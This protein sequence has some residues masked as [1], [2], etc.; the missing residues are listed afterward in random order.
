M[1]EHAYLSA[2]ELLS[3]A[4]LPH[5]EHL[6][7]IEFLYEDA[8]VRAYGVLHG[9]TGGTNRSYVELVNRTIEQ[10]PG[11]RLG[12]KGMRAMYKGLHG[13]LDDWLQVP[14]KDAFCFPLNLLLTPARVVRFVHAVLR[15]YLTKHDRFGAYG[16]NRLQDIGGSPAFHLLSP[17]ERRH[18]AGFMDAPAYLMEN[19]LRR[20][21]ESKAPPP[22]FPDPDW[23][24]LPLIEPFVNIPC[25]SVHMLEFA[26]ALARLRG[27]K[28]VSLFVG[29]I[30]NSD[31][32]W[33]QGYAQHREGLPAWADQQLQAIRQAACSHAERVHKGR[34]TPYKYAYAAAMMSGLAI[35]V[36]GYTALLRWLAD[37]L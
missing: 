28:E 29:E 25:R 18:L 12:E 34:L 5:V 10:A 1:T 20:K 23:G 33:Y 22:Q 35:P 30:H 27:E 19:L 17:T 15:E 14:L 36:L 13:E 21:G 26:V 37:F 9:L 2:D 32:A 4:V 31:M 7:N 3:R 16:T 11:I 8:T 6:D 24:W